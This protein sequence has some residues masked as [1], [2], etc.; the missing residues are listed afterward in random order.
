MAFFMDFPYI[1]RQSD[2]FFEG[3]MALLQRSDVERAMAI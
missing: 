3:R 2:V 1:L